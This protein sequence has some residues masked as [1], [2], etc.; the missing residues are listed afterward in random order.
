M[1]PRGSAPEIGH[2]ALEVRSRD[3]SPARWS[4]WLPR[5][6][7]AL[8]L[9]ATAAPWLGFVLLGAALGPQALGVLSPDLL[10]RLDVVVSIGLAMLGVFVGLGLGGAVGQGGAR[11]LTAAVIET[12]FTIV[13]VS[14]AMYV[15]LSTWALP[16]PA[17]AALVAVALGVCSCA[18]AALRV[19]ES[20]SPAARRASRIADLDD[21]PLIILGAFVVAIFGRQTGIVTGVLAAAAVGLTVGAA[22]WLL[23][24]R[25]YGQAERAVFVVGTI[26]LLGGLGAY[27]GTSPLLSG[28]A[29][30]LVWV[31]TPGAADRIIGADLRKL[32][33]PLVALLLLIAGAA[34]QW[35]TALLW[36]TAPLVLFRLTGKLLAGAL[37]ARIA[38][39]P[40][41]L[42][43]TV[44]VPPG[45]IGIALALNLEQVLTGGTLLLSG[46]TVAAVVSEVLAVWV[47]GGAED[48]R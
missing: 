4:T 3:G 29:A 24:E 27:M 28:C 10:R 36:I 48:V 22:G 31:R 39:V 8:G 34:I 32:Q 17:D 42:L 45:V 16:L 6:Q 46:I 33:H 15:L 30:A 5:R 35:N 1:L 21:L 44:L 13:V 18:S 14:G 37:A 40:T 47:L 12:F 20:G 38:D 11:L 19:P 9:S 41:G 25:A 26:V 43:A 7:A 2:D 23:F